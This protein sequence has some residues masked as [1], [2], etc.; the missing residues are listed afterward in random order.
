MDIIQY[1]TIDLPEVKKKKKNMKEK[2][3][4]FP[5]KMENTAL[6]YGE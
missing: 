2:E 5:Q 4:K 1:F 3:A 6:S